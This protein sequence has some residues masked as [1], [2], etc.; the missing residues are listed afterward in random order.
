VTHLIFSAIVLLLTSPDDA[1]TRL[2][3]SADGLQ[4]FKAYMET[5]MKAESPPLTES[6]KKEISGTVTRMAQLH[7]ILG[8]V[9]ATKTDFSKTAMKNL[10]SSITSKGPRVASYLLWMNA[11]HELRLLKSK[12]EILKAAKDPE[13]QKRLASEDAKLRSLLNFDSATSRAILKRSYVPTMVDQFEVWQTEALVFNSPDVN[14]IFA[15]IGTSQN[16]T[17]QPTTLPVEPIGIEQGSPQILQKAVAEKE[18]ENLTPKS[19][20]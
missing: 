7:A 17:T 9:E 3:N 16:S 10:Q 19:K 13:L 20:P 12:I 11:D 4:G 2:Q 18:S 8:S 1:I 5:Q 14:A 6:E 15:H